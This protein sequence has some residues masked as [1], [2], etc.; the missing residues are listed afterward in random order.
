MATTVE[1]KVAIYLR[2]ADDE[3]A[4]SAQ[5]QD[6]LEICQYQGWTNVEEYIDVLGPTAIEGA[7]RDQFDRLEAD[8][9][10]GNVQIVVILSKE[11]LSPTTIKRWRSRGVEI[12]HRDKDPDGPLMDTR[13]QAYGALW[14]HVDELLIRLQWLQEALDEAQPILGED[15]RLPTGATVSNLRDLADRTNSQWSAVINALDDMGTE[16]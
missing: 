5:I 12:F 13:A 6:A 15:W 1:P 2:V 10:A 4:R 7:N 16:K 14:R 3:L 11:W 9:D 8:V